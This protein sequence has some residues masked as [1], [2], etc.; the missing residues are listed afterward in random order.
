MTKITK[1]QNGF[2]PL[3]IM[4]LLVILAAIVIVYL[5]VSRAQG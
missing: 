1:T 5:R 2:I 4:L 3:V